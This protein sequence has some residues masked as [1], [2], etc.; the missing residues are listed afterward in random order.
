MHR[1]ILMKIAW[2]ICMTFL[3]TGCGTSQ[4]P[5]TMSGATPVKDTSAVQLKADPSLPASTIQTVTMHSDTLNK[6]MKMNVY[7]PKGYSSSHK[8]PVLYMI[9]GFSATYRGYFEELKLNELADRLIADG[10][11]VPV[12]IV[13]P[14][15]DNSYGINSATTTS[16]NLP[17]KPDI[18]LYY[19]RYEDYLIKEVLPYVDKHFSTQAEKQH[20]WIGGI[21]M[22]GFISLH[23]A[24]RHP[25]L[26]GKVGGHSPAIWL[27][28]SPDTYMTNWL[29]PD[30][31][32]R[33][34]RDPIIL[35]QSENLEGM[36]VYL[37]CGEQDEFQFYDGAKQVYQALTSRNVK[38][39]IHLYPGKHN[40]EYWSAHLEEY[41]KFYAG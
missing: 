9:H 25:D 24:F 10:Q 4:N 39:E 5:V 27:N 18:S 6:D 38:A 36:H 7:L 31:Q 11:I 15:V 35:A 20:R 26:F 2:V 29:Y 41:F 12:I 14:Q 40:S 16:L 19:G 13:C 8:Y 30:A 32:T 37:D 23:T 3:L 1:S 17:D 22:G 34:T 28:D 33:Q 21:S